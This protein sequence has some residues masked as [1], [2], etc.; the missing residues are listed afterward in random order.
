MADIAA[1]FHWSLAELAELSVE[2][3]AY[4]WGKAQARSPAGDGDE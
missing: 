4:W 2:D 1:V 3:L